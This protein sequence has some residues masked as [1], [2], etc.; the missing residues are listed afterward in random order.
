MPKSKKSTLSTRPHI[1][2]L[3]IQNDEANNTHMFKFN[4]GNI[5]DTVQN[6]G[7]LKTKHYKTQ[8]DNLTI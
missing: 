8:Y 6:A 5:T 2:I 1:L 4:N 3:Q 7:K